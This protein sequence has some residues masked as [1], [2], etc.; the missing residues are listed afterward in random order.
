MHVSLHVGLANESYDMRSALKL[1]RQAL[2]AN[3]WAVPAEGHE[4]LSEQ[5]TN[6][7]WLKAA[8]ETMDSWLAWLADHHSE[9]ALLSCVHLGD[10]LL[11]RGEHRTLV[12]GI[13]EHGT[14][15][16]L[17][18]VRRLDDHVATS[19][20][21][22]LLHGRA[23]RLSNRELAARST[24]N[25]LPRLA[26]WQ[27]AAGPDFCA[28][29]Y[30]PEGTEDRA[31]LEF[32]E[33]IGVPEPSTLKLPKPTGVKGLD[34]TRAEVLRRFNRL[35]DLNEV[36]KARAKKLRSAAV[37][38]LIEASSGQPF[39]IDPDAAAALLQTFE[40]QAKELAQAMTPQQAAQFLGRE[41]PTPDR[42][43]ESE[44]MHQ[45]DQLARKFE[46]DT[47]PRTPRAEAAQ[48]L[49]KARRLALKANTSLHAQDKKKYRVATNRL[50]ELIPALA[51]FQ[52]HPGPSGPGT[53][54]PDRVLQY[55]DPS[56]PPEELVPWFQ[57]WE[58]IG[59]PKGHHEVADYERGLDALRETAGD[60]GVRAYEAANH[61]AVRADLYRYAELF[62]R[63]GWYVDAEHEALLPI[64]DVLDFGVDHV[65]TQRVGRQRLVNNF[66][67]SVPGS[68]LM[69][70]AL[71]EGCRNV[72]EGIGRSVMN[73]TG[74]FM[75]TQVAREYMKSPEASYVI[76]PSNFVFNDI[77]QTVHNLAD[78]KAH[79]HWR[80]VDL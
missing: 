19:Y 54:I 42:V 8:H 36:K 38:E 77:L 58:T 35:L 68:P 44:V 59:L 71:H 13:R 61:A 25:Y 23:R 2:E 63:G 17:A 78:Y 62:A 10:A 7:A 39:A 37:A 50:R 40:D 26:K 33:R 79:G 69:E 73:M 64:T 47:K 57:S 18:I 56:P 30:S 41:L 43:S 3:G 14:L 15:T 20:V 31:V 75:F 70:K 34:N 9:H 55:W 32:F 72:V 60:I 12:N 46:V 53:P 11:V 48:A 5:F 22:E 16:C 51:E 76:L 80:H 24:G 67:G 65:L 1:N 49:Q 21:Q 45:L 4:P 28:I 52:L 29:P 27:E 6:I 66:I 74:P